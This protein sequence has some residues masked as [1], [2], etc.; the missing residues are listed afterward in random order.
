MKNEKKIRRMVEIAKMYYEDDIKQDDIAKIL[1]I[2][3]PLVS[4]IL[5]EAKSSGIVSIN[6]NSPIDEKHMI[7]SELLEKFN[8]KN[9]V[10]VDNLEDKNSLN[11][12]LCYEA[13]GM[14][15]SL[16]INKG[17]NSS[18]SR[19]KFNIG[20]GWGEKIYY[21]L[22]EIND[23]NSYLGNTCGLIG[24]FPSL[25]KSYHSNE[26]IRMFSEKTETKPEYVYA[27]AF[28]NSKE[29]MADY[30]KI[31]KL[32]DIE[33]L[34]SN[35]DIA[36]IGAENYPSIA[37]FAAIPWFRDKLH[38]SN[39]VGE[40]VN[41]YFDIDGNIIKDINDNTMHIPI[42]LLKK[43]T[44]ILVVTAEDTKFETIIGL[45]RAKL[46]TDIVLTRKMAL[47]LVKM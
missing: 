30:Q 22:G 3:R 19:E 25:N 20:L 4:K 28:F 15:N 38:K 36:I 24:N 16:M 27:P 31:S 8:L 40:V 12:K 33:K 18:E 26:I 41:H 10:V 42:E 39:A 7:E 6:I 14:M 21:T 32:N 43:T 17:L 44:R 1:D 5:A 46:V 45:I 11:K 37:D 35:L 29:E 9:V 47:E 34:W 13:A 2:S 23:M